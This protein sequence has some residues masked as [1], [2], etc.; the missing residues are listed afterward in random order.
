MYCPTK[1]PPV[2]NAKE[3][4]IEIFH[5]KVS[6]QTNPCLSLL[7]LLAVHND[8]ATCTEMTFHFTVEYLKLRNGMRFLGLGQIPV[9][10]FTVGY[11]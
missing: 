5:V 2:S 8:A 9:D 3:F 1:W 10:H 11:S 6:E 4:G 7:V